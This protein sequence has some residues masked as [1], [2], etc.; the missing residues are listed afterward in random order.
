MVGQPSSK[1]SFVILGNNVGP[2]KL[3]ALEGHNIRTLDE[4]GFMN[5]IATR[6]GPSARGDSKEF[7]QET[8]ELVK[9][10]EAA[11]AVKSESGRWVLQCV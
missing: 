9:H 7:K 4:D 5:L 10:E 6:K 8:G 1:T 3:K 2:N 11:K